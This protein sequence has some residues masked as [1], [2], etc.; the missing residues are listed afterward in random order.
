V[1]FSGMMGKIYHNVGA[2]CNIKQQVALSFIMPFITPQK[3]R[4]KYE[5]TP[6]ICKEIL[7]NQF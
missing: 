6:M 3:W 1:Q 2:I 5:V 4:K 7:P